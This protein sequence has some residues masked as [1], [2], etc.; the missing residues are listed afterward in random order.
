M[1]VLVLV[2]SSIILHYKVFAG[3]DFSRWNDMRNIQ[4]ERYICYR[5]T[6]SI[7]IDGKLTDTTWEKAPWTN[8]FVDIEGDLKP[9]P[10]FKT[11]LKMLW[12]DYYFY[13]GV[14]MEEPHVWGNLV[15][16]DQTSYKNNDFEIFIDPNG[17]NHEYYEIEI[18]ALNAVWELFLA[19]P[20]KDTYGGPFVAD[21]SWDLHGLKTAVYVNG[22]LNDPRDIDHGWSIEFALLWEELAE[23]AHCSCPPEHGDQWRINFSRVE[24]AHE[25]ITAEFS[26]NNVKNN[27]YRV[28]KDAPANNWVWSPHGVVAM[29]LPEM[30]G[31][32]QFSKNPAGQK[33]DEFKP[34]ETIPARFVLL[35]IYNAQRVYLE[36]NKKWAKSLSELGLSFDKISHVLS[37]PVMHV[38]GDNWDAIV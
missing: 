36:K 34:D 1:T 11:R 5:S 17:D 19:K 33:Y 12:D 38:T 25:I 21:S 27:G 8:Y 37:Q 35:D 13:I 31:Y 15:F 2:F 18:N 30:F 10:H 14:E 16:H 22:S 24:L 9:L 3:E 20:Y 28:V 32:V 4:P 23:Y 29:H 26:G 7:E 6:G